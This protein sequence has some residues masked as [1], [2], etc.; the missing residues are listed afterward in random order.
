[1]GERGC[2]G[3]DPLGL[4]RDSP[5]AWSRGSCGEGDRLWD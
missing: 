4:R 2:G 5:T 3:F 1:M